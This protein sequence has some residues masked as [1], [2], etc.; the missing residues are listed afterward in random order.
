[1]MHFYTEIDD[2]TTMF[3]DINTGDYGQ[4]SIRLCFEKPIANGFASGELVLPDL[5]WTKQLSMT[6]DDVYSLEEYARNNS[7][8]IWELAREGKGCLQ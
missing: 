6:E 4:E 5:I 1:M 3:S 2:W 7:P 8:L